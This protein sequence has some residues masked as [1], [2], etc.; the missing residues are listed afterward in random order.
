MRKSF[1]YAC[2]IKHVIYTKRKKEMFQLCMHEKNRIRKRRFLNCECKS[3]K[4][5]A[6]VIETSSFVY[7][8]L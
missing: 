8:F 3:N 7:T 6:H 4:N 5:V 2:M 1:N